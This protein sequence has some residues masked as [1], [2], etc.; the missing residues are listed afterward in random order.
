[1]REVLE[2]LRGSY[3][4][5]LAFG[6][7]V[8][9]LLAF[10]M[11]GVLLKRADLHSLFLIF[12]LAGLLSVSLFL[13]NFPKLLKLSSPVAAALTA[14]FPSISGLQEFGMG[15]LGFFSG[16]L[17]ALIAASLGRFEKPIRVAAWGLIWGNVLLIVLTV[18]V[19]EFP[20]LTPYL[21]A[22]AGLGLLTSLLLPQARPAGGEGRL[23]KEALPIFL[24]YLILGN[25]YLY[26]HAK[27]PLG[28]DNLI[29]GL[30][31]FGALWVRERRQELLLPLTVILLGLS[32]I[33]IG[34]EGGL[35]SL[36][37]IQSSAGFADL[38]AL[39]TLFKR[40]SSLRGAGVVVGAMVGG[41][42]AGLPFKEFLEW[43]STAPLIGNLAISLLF[44]VS[45]LTLKESPSLEERV[46]ALGLS[47]ESFSNREWQ[48]LEMTYRGK[49]L[50]E[51]AQEIG[52]SESSVK[53]YLGRIYRKTGVGGKRELLVKL[54]SSQK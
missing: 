8:L 43:S 46:R 29:Y 25:S 50:K 30:A 23:V 44:A 45:Y 4:G 53:T 33:A 6:L 31:V 12:H 18:A 49:S 54:R 39:N 15:A 24:I 40:G 13:Y 28:L 16:I 47:R 17:S 34:I 3:T 36:A 22:L 10:P 35:F 27:S 32:V 11:E 20:S 14:L 9:W 7:F 51:I 19:K 1:M 52:V 38:F 21:T 26:L 48:V 42:F 41:I 37:L 5:V 2:E